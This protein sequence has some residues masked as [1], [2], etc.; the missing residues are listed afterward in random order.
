MLSSA[1]PRPGGGGGHV[2]VEA[3]L[4]QVECG[5]RGPLK[6]VA[7]CAFL[8]RDIVAEDRRVDGSAEDAQDRAARVDDGD[9]HAGRCVPAGSRIAA[10]VVL[11]V[12][13]AW[14]RM[15]GRHRRRRS[16]R[17][18]PARC[19]RGSSLRTATGTVPCVSPSAR[20]TKGEPDSPAAG[21]RPFTGRCECGVGGR[22]LTRWRLRIG[23]QQLDGVDEDPV[24]SDRCRC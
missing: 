11:A 6:N 9:R 12:W 20:A 18:R 5:R 17:R 10:R 23:E 16:G 7:V 22:H 19:R 13:A 24:A 14:P 3:G 15:Q 21:P 2:G 8:D 1:R 4:A